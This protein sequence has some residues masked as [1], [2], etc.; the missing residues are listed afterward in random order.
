MNFLRNRQHDLVVVLHH[1]FHSLSGP[2]PENGGNV[3]TFREFL[4]FP[5]LSDLQVLA[6]GISP[7]FHVKTAHFHAFLTFLHF[8]A[9]L[10][11]LD[12]QKEPTYNVLGGTY[13]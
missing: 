10:S 11:L 7:T 12:L 1:V 5:P 13:S 2:K 9:L 4:A 6:A 3:R 8:W